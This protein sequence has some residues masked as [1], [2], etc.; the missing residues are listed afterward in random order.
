[1]I[2]TRW[3]SCLRVFII[4]LIDTTKTKTCVYN[5]YTSLHILVEIKWSSSSHETSSTRTNNQ[6]GF[7]PFS[8]R[9]NRSANDSH[10]TIIQP[11]DNHLDHLPS[12]DPHAIIL[13][14]Q[15]HSFASPNRP[16]PPI[17]CERRKNRTP[18]D[19]ADCHSPI[20]RWRRSIRDE[21]LG[22]WRRWSIDDELQFRTQT[23]LRLS[24]IL[25]RQLRAQRI[26]VD[27]LIIYRGCT[28]SDSSLSVSLSLAH[29]SVRIAI[30]QVFN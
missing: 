3:V 15:H 1:M 2:R 16:S 17:S 22:P 9:E 5:H 28:S 26:I 25:S 6:H 8:S 10:V 21:L 14:Q 20:V 18:V 19:N 12:N 29:T 4:D 11:Q 23:C 30:A 13:N 24:F 7:V 27:W